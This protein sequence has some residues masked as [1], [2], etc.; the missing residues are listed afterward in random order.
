MINSENK[1]G[2]MGRKTLAAIAG[3]AFLVGACATPGPRYT[4]YPPAGKSAVEYQ[5]DI[6]ACQAWASSRAG[7][8]SQRALTKGAEGAVFLG[9]LGAG[10]GWLGGDARLGGLVGA[11]TGAVLGGAQGSR[12][13]QASYDFAY[14]DCLRQKGY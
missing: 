13:A 12:Q 2:R 1:R 14:R 10:L 11:G 7:A 6:V 3:A 8:S 5:S 4:P 9:L